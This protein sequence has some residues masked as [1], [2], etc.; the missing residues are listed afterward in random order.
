MIELDPRIRTANAFRLFSSVPI[1]FAAEQKDALKRKHATGQMESWGPPFFF[2]ALWATV[3][4][5]TGFSDVWKLGDH[6][7]TILLGISFI[8]IFAYYFVKRKYSDLPT[9]NCERE[10]GITE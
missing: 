8:S 6:R 2:H 7:Y 9:I 4:V 10:K 5:L 3:A 1:P